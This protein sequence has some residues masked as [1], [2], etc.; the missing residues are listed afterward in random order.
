MSYHS[1]EKVFKQ[2]GERKTS[3]IKSALW[4]DKLSLGPGALGRAGRQ[5]AQGT[6]WDLLYAWISSSSWTSSSPSPA[7]S[8]ASASASGET[9]PRPSHCGASPPS[10]S[11]SSRGPQRCP[12]SPRL[13]HLPARLLPTHHLPCEPTPWLSEHRV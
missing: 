1:S 9:S 3:L 8:C 6:L 12:A 5:Q 13:R 10:P 7:L 2:F 4:P 11:G